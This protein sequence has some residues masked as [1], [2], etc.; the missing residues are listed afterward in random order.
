M[1]MADSKSVQGRSKRARGDRRRRDGQRG[2]HTRGA[3]T[4]MHTPTQTRT[5]THTHT[6]THTLDKRTDH[7]LHAHA[8]PLSLPHTHKTVVVS[9]SA[10]PDMC[11]DVYAGIHVCADVCASLPL[12]VRQPRAFSHPC[13]LP[14]YHACTETQACGTLPLTPPL[15]SQSPATHANIHVDTPPA[16]SF[17]RRARQ[18]VMAR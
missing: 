4:H 5:P 11:T 18:A 7:H 6:H 10:W 9:S 13:P 16:L 15:P 8:S 3:H 17:G 1:V 12:R 14:P 2:T